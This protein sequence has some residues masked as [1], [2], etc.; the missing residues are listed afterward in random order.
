MRLYRLEWIELKDNK[1]LLKQEQIFG[2]K[3]DAVFQAHS[4]R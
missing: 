4:K 1:L 3:E 2:N